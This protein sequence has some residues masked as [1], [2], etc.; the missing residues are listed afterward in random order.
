[1]SIVIN[2]NETTGD[3]EQVICEIS[4]LSPNTWL[5]I[6]LNSSKLVRLKTNSSGNKSLSIQ[7]ISQGLMG[8]LRNVGS[9]SINN[10]HIPGSGTIC[11]MSNAISDD[12]DQSRNGT[13]SLEVR[14]D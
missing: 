11:G 14:Y 10:Q 9:I 5:A 6:F 3:P 1:V 7:S 4:G 2:R 8:I 13:W 12:E